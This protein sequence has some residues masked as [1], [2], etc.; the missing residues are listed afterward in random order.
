MN[1]LK[2]HLEYSAWA[3]RRLLEAA[4]ALTRDELTRDFGTADKSVLGTLAHVY[5]ADRAWLARVEGHPRDRFFD[6]DEPLDLA[7]LERDW[8]RVHAGWA[9]WIETADPEAVLVYQDFRGNTW[10]NP[11]WQI[12]M[13]LVNHASHHRGQVAGFL[14]AMG[15]VPPPLDE[16][17]FYRDAG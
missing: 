11:M 16:I 7:T 3:S 8:P 15:H 13:H 17:R 12:V 14:R 6:A 4:S 5:G 2:R 1:I 10:Q 9:A